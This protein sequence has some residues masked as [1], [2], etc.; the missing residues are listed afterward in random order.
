MTQRVQSLPTRYKHHP[1]GTV[2]AHQIQ[3][4]PT[5][6]SH[7]PL[8]TVIAHW[9]QA[10]L[11]RYSH[12]PLGTGVTPRA[13][14]ALGWFR[15]PLSPSF[16]WPIPGSPETVSTCFPSSAGLPPLNAH[17]HTSTQALLQTRRI[18]G[19]LTPI[20]RCPGSTFSQRQ[21]SAPDHACTPA[22]QAGTPP[23]PCPPPLPTHTPAGSLSPRRPRL[24]HQEQI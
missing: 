18:A 8:G 7:H 4:S 21:P 14:A 1:P 15:H 19:I 6:H 12:H 3:A 20:D 11:T 2:I 10:P 22:G 13:Q 16:P 23:F 9:I 5:R 24:C 17:G